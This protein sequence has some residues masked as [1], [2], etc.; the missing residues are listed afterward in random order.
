MTVVL[1]GAQT[2]VTAIL[3]DGW[4]RVRTALAHRWSR[5]TDEPQSDIEH[6]LDAAHTQASEMTADHGDS[7]QALLRAYWAGYLAAALAERPAL[8]DL[9]RDLRGTLTAPDTTASVQNVNSGTATT[10][11]QGRDFSGGI[12]F[13]AP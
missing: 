8:L 10:V 1:P 13:R 9:V 6:R 12:T 7:E 2:L 4:T 11:V 3:T 5:Q